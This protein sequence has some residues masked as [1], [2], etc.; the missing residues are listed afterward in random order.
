MAE[1]GLRPK[2]ANA[3]V[4][5]H[6]VT[7]TRFVQGENTGSKPLRDLKGYP[8]LQHSWRWVV[9]GWG[10]G[11]GSASPPLLCSYTHSDKHT[12][13]HARLLP[14]INAPQIW[15]V[16][17][18]I[19]EWTPQL[20]QSSLHA[21]MTTRNFATEV[22]CSSTG[23]LSSC[24]ALEDSRTKSKGAPQVTSAEIWPGRESVCVF[25]LWCLHCGIPW[26]QMA[27]TK[28]SREA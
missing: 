11:R 1:P 27:A 15:L 28:V 12:C 3:I 23:K 2:E 26:N 9:V 22:G 16:Y 17:A 24:S 8:V 25:S 4:C 10:G 7:V 20:C 18:H 6:P 13:S 14:A 21:C 19:P 5:R